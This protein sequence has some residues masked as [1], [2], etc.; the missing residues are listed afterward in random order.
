MNLE[1]EGK[2]ALVTAASQGLGLGCASAL[3]SEGA[4]VAICA[5]DK[6]RV[7]SAA[8]EIGQRSGATVVGFK[9]DMTSRDEVTRLVRDT[10]D[11]LGSIDILVCN[12]GNPPGGHLLDTGDEDWDMGLALVLRPAITLTRLV[13]LGM[14][15]RGFGRVVFISSAYGL[16][17]NPGSVISS[18]LRAGLHALAKCAARDVGGDGVCVNV[19]CPGYFNTP[20]LEE[21]AR[22]EA[23]SGS[24]DAA[25]IL[26][27]WGRGAPAGRLG[28]PADLGALVAFLASP[29][30]GFIQGTVLT[31]DGG[32]LRTW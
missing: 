25:E 21:Y 28:E 17:P 19:V 24:A 30:S 16:E 15:D 20:L 6:E 32:M 11:A 18:T 3:A 8:A 13:V 2:V 31:I 23:S 5:R 26:E 9:A 7:E 10:E 1:L 29:R 22:K 27:S 14:R 12:T 4:K